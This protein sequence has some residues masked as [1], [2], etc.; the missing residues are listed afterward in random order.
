MEIKPTKAR[1]RSRYKVDT[2]PL[3]QGMPFVLTDAAHP[4]MVLKN[5]SQFLVLDRAASIP[6]CNTLGYGYYRYDTRFLSEWEF[7]LNGVPMSLL[8]SNVSEGYNATFLHTNVQLEGIPQQTITVRRELVVHELLWEKIII[9]NFL[10]AC[11]DCELTIKFQSDFADMFEVRG[12][13]REYRGERMLPVASRDLSTLFLAYKGTDNILLE[14]IIEFH[15]RKPIR[16]EDGEVT[17]RME[18]HGRE[19]QEFEI[20]LST[21]QNG[22]EQA[23]NPARCG[24]NKAKL[25][26]DNQY[27]SWASSWATIDTEHELFDAALERGIRDVF[28]LRQPTPKGYGIAAGIPWYTAVFGRDSAITAWQFLPYTKD[29][30]RETIDVLGKYQGAK[31]DERTEE[32]PGRIMHEYRYGELSRSHLIPHTP[33]YGTVDATQLWLL[34]LCEY[35]D[36]TG[37]LEYAKKTLAQE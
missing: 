11:V 16:I 34:L 21:A 3:C 26:T 23:L 5:G 14:S 19:R 2:R 28:I 36:W 15:G 13:N 35:I 9:E 32:S 31:E 7:F 27:K 1:K 6:A 22:R 4:R 17:F 25:L 33:Y 37:D 29:L 24:F 12:L 30:A 18:L 8:S 10:N 20:S